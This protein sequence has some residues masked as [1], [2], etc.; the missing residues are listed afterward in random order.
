MQFYFDQSRVEHTI[1][2]HSDKTVKVNKNDSY[3]SL[4]G[5]VINHI[6]QNQD[7]SNLEKIYYLLA[8]SLALI[9][10]HCNKQRDIA[11]AADSWAKKLNCSRSQIFTMQKNLAAKGYFILYKDKNL[12]GQNNRNLIYP[13]L[14]DNVFELL[15]TSPD[16]SGEEHLP[17]VDTHESKREYLDR[18]KLFIN[19]S[20]QTLKELCAHNQRTPF[21]KLI[22]LDLYTQCYKKYMAARTERPTASFSLITST[23][24]LVQKYCCD[25]RH[26]SKTL[27]MLAAVGLIK[28]EHF[29]LKKEAIAQGRQDKSLW[30]ITLLSEI[31]QSALKQNNNTYTDDSNSVYPI[32]TSEQYITTMIS[33]LDQSTYQARSNPKQDDVVACIDPEVANS[34]P[35]NNKNLILKNIFNSNL[36]AKP[37]VSLFKNNKKSEEELT[38]NTQNKNTSNQSHKKP[39]KNKDF[40]ICTAL[41]K[42]KLKTLSQD[43]ADKARKFAYSLFSK[44]LA[45]GYAASL[46][47]HELAKQ[48][49]HHA[50]TWKPT[51][52]YC[53]SKDKQIDTALSVAW[54]A[55][56]KGTWQAP[57]EWNKA[58]ALQNEYVDYRNKYLESGILSQELRSLEPAVTGLLGGYHDLTSK[59]TKLVERLEN[60]N[61]NI[62]ELKNL[63]NLAVVANEPLSMQSKTSDCFSTGSNVNYKILASKG[64]YLEQDGCQSYRADPSSSGSNNLKDC[65]E[66]EKANNH[67]V[68]LSNLSE[69]QK[70][71]KI[72]GNEQDDLMSIVTTNSKEYFA[73]LKM[74][75]INEQGELVMTLKPITEQRFAGLLVKES[76]KSNK[77]NKMD[78]PMVKID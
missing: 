36:R 74:L 53:N 69:N 75:E 10:F 22:W 47:K 78:Y 45:K 54:K 64:C 21:H 63:E 48:F 25:K 67:N 55:V 49:I 70:Y 19:I 13:T 51:K 58:Q 37:K 28:R 38:N 68:D 8:D 43:K 44:K 71:F 23:E 30:K 26:I 42:E 57:L 60:P 7:L 20:Y 1:S 65:F 9:N 41:I 11:L 27:I 5:C 40:N 61:R 17:Y 77:I 18:S 76:L 52:I 16:R 62:Q 12:Y 4:P 56:V 50:A 24:E 46:D 32:K 33:E 73:K 66:V 59:I 29:Y 39:K 34:N 31:S 72:S 15:R 14:P 35:Y 2:N 3:V 6:L